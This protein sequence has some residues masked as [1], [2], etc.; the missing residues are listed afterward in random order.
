[1]LVVCVQT[2]VLSRKL[3]EGTLTLETWAKKRRPVHGSTG[4]ARGSNLLSFKDRESMA[5]NVVK[6]NVTVRPVQNQKIF[7]LL[8]SL[9]G[10]RHP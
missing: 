10:R 5:Y 6:V 1:M 8:L 4:R 3:T 7:L 9:M 2:P